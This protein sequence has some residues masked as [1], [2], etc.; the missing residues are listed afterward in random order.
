MK[1]SRQTG[2]VGARDVTDGAQAL[3]ILLVIPTLNEAQHIVDCLDSLL[4]DPLLQ[5]PDRCSVVVADGGSTDGTVDLVTAYA[6]G[7][8]CPVHVMH[9]PDRIQSAGINR[10]VEHYGEGFHLLLRCDAHA[11]YPQ[12]FASDLVAAF[13]DGRE[14]ASVVVPMVSTGRTPFGQAA[15]W[16]VDTPAGSGGSAHRGG[17]RSGYVDHGHHALMD[18]AWF[19]KVGGYDPDFSH[20]EDAELD[21]RLSQ[22][23]GRIWLAGDVRLGYIMRDTLGAL[24]RQYRNYGAGRARTILKHGMRPQLRQLIPVL[25]FVVCAL[26]VLISPLFPVMLF[27]PVAYLVALAAISGLGVRKLG[28]KGA[29]AGVALFAMHMS[30]AIG[31][32]GMTLRHF[33]RG[34]GKG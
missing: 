9:N 21:W 15:A 33:W 7:A 14:K 28:G 5:D 11:L 17:R 32:L 27:W 26:A 22:A 16:V 18:L 1:K 29:W 19:R 31:F 6:A 24:S 4:C 8:P 2:E 20:N 34:I 23:G 12:A 10:A 13:R 3:R 30:W 25:N